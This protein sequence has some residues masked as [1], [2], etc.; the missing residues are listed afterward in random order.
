MSLSTESDKQHNIRTSISL[1]MCMWLGAPT[2]PDISS[3]SF[4]LVQRLGWFRHHRVFWLKRPITLPL[5]HG[6][7]IQW[8]DN[9]PILNPILF[10]IASVAIRFEFELFPNKE[11]CF[12]GT[13]IQIPHLQDFFDVDTLRFALHCPMGYFGE[14]WQ[15]QSRSECRK[16]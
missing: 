13:T 15:L 8:G 2:S 7:N 5:T 6:P 4:F 14:L 12:L 16:K 1:S 3:I 9:F 11:I 10:C